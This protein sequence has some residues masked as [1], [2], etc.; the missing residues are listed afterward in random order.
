VSWLEAAIYSVLTS[1][2]KKRFSRIKIAQEADTKIAPTKKTKARKA[3]ETTQDIDTKAPTPKKAKVVKAETPPKGKA[4]ATAQVN[5]ETEDEET[6][7]G[8]EN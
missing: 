5:A 3:D 6:E 4:K 2:R 1:I 7:A 8:D